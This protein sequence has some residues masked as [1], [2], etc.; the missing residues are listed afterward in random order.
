MFGSYNKI[1]TNIKLALR[2]AHYFLL[3]SEGTSLIEFALLAPTFILL[4]L[5][6]INIGLMMTVQNALEA[7]VR[8]AARYGITGQSQAGLT[9]DQ[10]I[11][12]EIQKVAQDRS[13]GII[14]PAKLQVTVTA[15]PDL[16]QTSTGVSGSFGLSGQAVLYKLSYPWD[17]F[18][19]LFGGSNIVT[20][21]AQTPVV[22][23]D[24]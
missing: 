23:E 10:S 2:K 21:D 11:L 19:S 1:S 18:F 16:T 4:V 15:Y 9:R 8:E 22:N 5:G 3:K 17:T 12:Q 14:N 24:F 13:G 20:L 7:S 6:I